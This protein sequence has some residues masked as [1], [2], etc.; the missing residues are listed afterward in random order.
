MKTSI[1]YWFTIEPYV[2]VGIAKEYVLLYNTLDGVNIESKEAEVVQLLKEMLNKD[3]CCV[4]LLTNERYQQKEVKD[5]I[6]DLREKYMGDI[7]EVALSKGKPIQIL[8]LYN[9]SD[10]H[11]I[12][13]EH[14]FSSDKN[15]LKN[16]SRINIHLD[17]TTDILKLI[18]FLDSIP[19]TPLF[20]IIGNIMEVKQ[21]EKLLLFLN[22]SS[23]PKDI[24]CSYLDVIPLQP[25]IEND[26]LY[27]ISIHFPIDM[28]QW[29][30]SRQILL[31][32]TLPVEYIFN[33]S[34]IDDY[35]Q[36]E[37]LIEQFNIE[38]YQ[39][40]PVYTGDNIN[41]FEKN[42]FLKKED[43]LATSMTIK[44]IFARQAM[45]L[46][47]FGKIN[48]MPNG[49]V[50]ANLNYPALGNIYIDSINEI[51]QKE[52]DEGKSW[53]RIR[54]QAQIGRAHV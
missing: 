6:S 31:S 19:G 28:A 3:N 41:F 38:K 52:I 9:F 8:P 32:Q 1:N 4:V 12:Y 13:K 16:L 47:D 26:F 33:I 5:F 7:I 51:I 20:N 40:T 46:H 48:I 44:K 50:Y 25:I 53:F 29:N 54:N 39:L 10:K 22:N 42:V 11:E 43:I 34:S 36:A 23:S 49:D 30:K 21:F 17:S 14:N 24:S 2:F 18:S 27:R 35:Q 45:N 37:V 15:E